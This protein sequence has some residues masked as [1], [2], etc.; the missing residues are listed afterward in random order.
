MGML[1]VS[2]VSI[3]VY[4]INNAVALREQQFNR[5]VK[6]ALINVAN[7]VEQAETFNFLA[8]A[9]DFSNYA[10]QSNGAGNVHIVQHEVYEPNCIGGKPAE[11]QKGDMRKENISYAGMEANSLV[12]ETM[13]DLDTTMTMDSSGCT[14]YQS[15]ICIQVDDSAQWY[16][17]THNSPEQIQ[18]TLL[19][20]SNKLEQRRQMVSNL[21]LHLLEPPSLNDRVS[22]ADLQ[23]YLNE[24]LTR[25]D[26]NTDYEFAVYSTYG[27]P[28][29]NSVGYQ[30]NMPSKSH[31]VILFPN[32]IFANPSQLM[33]FFPNK[34]TYILSSLGVMA[35]SSMLIILVITLCFVYTVYI[36]F[37]QKK[38]SDMKTDFINNMTHELKTPVATISLASEMLMS[39]NVITDQARLQ[40]FAGV[41]NEE[42]KRLGGQVE[43]V[44][45]MAVLDKGEAK[46]NLCEV[47]VHERIKA[48]ADKMALQ[49]DDRGGSFALKLEATSTNVLAD[50]VHFTNIITNLV[51]NAIKY[52]QDAP[53]VTISTKDSANGIVISV[54]DTGIGMNKEQQK[55]VFEKFYR[56]PTGNIHNV[57]G[58]GL[59]LSYVKAMV[60][61]HGGSIRLQS[62]I[63]QGS[64]FGVFLPYKGPINK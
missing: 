33:L 54:T 47:D 45:Q 44:L 20:Q 27:A 42:N 16:T 1:V 50:E 48:I 6:D 8:G 38:L 55:R 39:S 29:Y 23:M 13:V 24:E 37:R 46:L 52:S 9:D 57:K 28:I 40:R 36:I 32:D 49:M 17:L 31:R 19:N 22:K 11:W 15:V 41:I 26:I 14:Y 18:Y 63:H 12:P 34:D 10:L 51:D 7:R 35:F 43:K 62:E 25:R 53:H 30:T 59:G 64:T 21:F 5:H 58:F 2:L 3:Q 60:E 4:W 56:V 61:A